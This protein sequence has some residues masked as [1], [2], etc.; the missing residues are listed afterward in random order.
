M[1]LKPPYRIRDLHGNLRAPPLG[2]PIQPTVARQQDGRDRPFR[3]RDVLH[4]VACLWTYGGSTP[5][6]RLPRFLAP[7]LDNAIIFSDVRFTRDIRVIPDRFF[8]IKAKTPAKRQGDQ[9]RYVGVRSR[10][11]V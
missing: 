8:A 11:V 9:G 5:A 1:L 2:K 3:S 7:F 6:R 4:A 10:Y